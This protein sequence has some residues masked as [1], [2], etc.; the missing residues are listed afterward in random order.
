LRIGCVALH[1]LAASAVFAGCVVFAA[2][3]A[4]AAGFLVIAAFSFF[5][6]AAG[7]GSWGLHVSEMGESQVL[8]QTRKREQQNKYER[9][10]FHKIT[11]NF[12]LSTRG[13]QSAMLEFFVSSGAG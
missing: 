12:F 5:P 11:F 9:F 4:L 6:A 10:E 8:S 7:L 1:V 13:A 3:L 2:G